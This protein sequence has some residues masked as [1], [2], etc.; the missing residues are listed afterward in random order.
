MF[1]ISWF[2]DILA[3][4]GLSQKSARIL[5]LGLDNAGKTTLLHML[6]DDRVAQHVPTLHPHS[7]ELVV[8][9]IRFKTFDLGGH[10]T[11]RRI[12]K[13]YFAAVDA[14]VFMIDT[15]DRSRFD[16]AREEL[17]QLLETEELSNVPFV[18][19]G[20]KIDKPDA[21]SEDELRQHLNLF[22]NMTISGNVKGNSG[23]RPVELFMCS[24]IRRMG[25]A[26]AFK[27]ISQFLT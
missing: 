18:V 2:K 17:K 15:T 3:H 25:Y 13:D 26:A 21:A 22:S 14:V 24:V 8:G 19:L 6:K 10:E 9:K 23:V 4:L 7:E 12:W 27:W 20:N 11:A 1:I 16:E 5:F